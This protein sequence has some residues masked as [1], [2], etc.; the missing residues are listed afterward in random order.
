MELCLATFDPL[1]S[2]LKPLKLYGIRISSG[3]LYLLLTSAQVC[4]GNIGSSEVR[5]GGP[6]RTESQNCEK[7]YRNSYIKWDADPGP[8]RKEDVGC[9]KRAPLLCQPPPVPAPV[10]V[11]SVLFT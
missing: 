1:K 3:Y 8:G 2:V 9:I 6:G 10:S 7:K 5:L 11:L 4:N